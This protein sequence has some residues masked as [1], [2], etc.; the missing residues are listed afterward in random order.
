MDV[1]APRLGEISNGLTTTMASRPAL[2]SSSPKWVLTVPGCRQ[3][4][5]TPVPSSLL[6]SSYVNSTLASLAC[7]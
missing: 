2:P 3:L 5:V 4:A 7:P 6:A 1:R